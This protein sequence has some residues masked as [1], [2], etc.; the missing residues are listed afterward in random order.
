MDRVSCIEYVPD[1]KPSVSD[2]IERKPQVVAG[3]RG[4][5]GHARGYVVSGSC[6]VDHL[7]LS[8]PE[9]AIAM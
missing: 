9:A 5:S 6:V 7:S 4:D 3:R 2:H 1:T 8:H